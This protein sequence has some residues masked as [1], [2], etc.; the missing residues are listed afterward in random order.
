MFTGIVE[1]VGSIVR[2]E[3]GSEALGLEVRAGFSPESVAAGDSVA[4]DGV[5][6]TVTRLAEEVLRFDLSH[7]TA[8]ATTL[9]G[10]KAGD[11][12]HLERA[13]ALGARLGGH[14]VTGH[15]DGTGEL[16]RREPRGENLDLILRAPAPVAPYLV[17]KGSVAVDGVSLTVNQ[18]RGDQF[19]VTLVPHTLRYTTLGER[20]PGDGL[21]LEA[22]ILGKY[23][24]HFVTG[25]GGSHGGG[26]DRRMLEEHGFLAPE[27]DS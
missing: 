20:R 3:R 24:R 9:R 12:V 8:G 1:E 14:L 21:N 23:V 10:R 4:V 6:L 5:C 19:R 22:D 16:L 7:E 15:V 27:R 25:A 17:P 11:R 13:L 2:V 26:V 18:P